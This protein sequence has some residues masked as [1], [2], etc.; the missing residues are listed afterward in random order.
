MLLIFDSLSDENLFN[1]ALAHLH[2]NYTVPDKFMKIN[3]LFFY[4]NGSLHFNYT[5]H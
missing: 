1:Q 5:F 3:N 2:F 4:N